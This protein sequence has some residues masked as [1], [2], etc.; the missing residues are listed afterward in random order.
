MAGPQVTAT[1]VAGV[2]RSARSTVCV[3]LPPPAPMYNIE[4]GCQSA[5]TRVYND[6]KC[7]GRR[8]LQQFPFAGRERSITRRLG[9]TTP[10]F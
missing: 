2:H 4:Q 7:R 9:Q 6:L 1:K 10:A 8:V 5:Q 3:Q